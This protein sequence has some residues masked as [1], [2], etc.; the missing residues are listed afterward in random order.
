MKHD[1][2]DNQESKLADHIN[3]ILTGSE[4]AKFAVGYLFLSGL[5]TIRE[6]LDELKSLRILIGNTSNRETLE[7]ITEGFQRLELAAEVDERERYLKR[8]V[9]KRRSE[10]TAENL[11]HSIEKIDQTD[12]SQELVRLLI[13]MIEEKRLLVRIYTKGRLHAKA[14]I[15]DYPNQERYENGIAIVGS[16]NLTLSGLTHNTEL[17]V[18]VHGN[19]NHLRL[20]Q[21]FDELW[22]DAQ[23]FNPLLTEE[24]RESWAAAMVTPYDVYMKTLY[25]LVADRLDEGDR[26]E[27]LWDDELT[28]SLADFQKTAV[29]QAVQMIRDTGGAFISDVVGLGKSYIGAAVVKHFVRTQGATPLIICPKSLEE[30]WQD[31]NNEFS[32]GA[33]ILPMSLLRSPSQASASP[34]LERKTYRACDFV[35]IDESH[36][37][38]HH[39]SQRYEVMSDF[40]S[41]GLKKVC[42]ITATPR[43]RGAQDVYNQIKL[44]HQD[45]ITGLPVDPPNLKEYFKLVE[46]GEKRLQ[47][48]LVHILIR[49]TRRHI[50]RWY[51]YAQDTSQALKEFSDVKARPYICGEKKAYVLVGGRHQFFPKRELETLRYS[52]E[53]TYTGLYDRIRGYLGGPAGEHYAP[54]P[55]KELTYARY[56]LWHYVRPEK[57]KSAP[58][59]DLQ[60]AGINLRGLVRVMLF[61]R[62]ESSVF[63][64]R[65]TLERLDKIHGHFLEA[66][67]QGFVPAGQDAQKLLYESDVYDDEGLMDALY[68]C[69]GRYH[70]TDFDE[71][72]LRDHLSADQE[73]VRKILKLVKPI[74]PDQ[75]AKIQVLLGGLR[76]GIPQRRGKVLIF[77]QYADTAQYLY[78]NLN[79]GEE[80]SDIASI[81]GTGKSKARMAARFSPLSNRHMDIREDEVNVLVSTDVMSEGLNLQDCDVVV[82]YDLHWNPVRLIQRL[83]RID[84]IG[85][86]NDRVWGFNFLPERKLEKNLGLHETLKRRIQEIHDTIGEDAAILDKEEQINEEAMFAI[87]ERRGE[88]LSLFE[89]E[90]GEFLDI[91]EAEEL[92]RALRTNEPEEYERIANLREGIRSARGVFSNT[93]RF[94]LCQAGRYQQLFLTD[95]DGTVVSREV[96]LVLGRVKCSRAE[97]TAALPLDHNRVVMKVLKSFSDEVKHRKAQQQHGLSLTVGQTYVL[98]ELR[99]FYSR[100]ADEDTDLKGQVVKLEEAFRRPATAA[101]RRQ[102]NILRRNGVVGNPLVRAL[103]DLY[104][105]HGLHEQVDADRIRHEQ[106]SEEFPR[107]ICSEAFV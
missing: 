36:N 53:D 69:S 63:A 19:Q 78:E 54:R 94:I 29:R 90:Q 56:G 96:P 101:I 91:S 58:Y 87:Y 107:I 80:R 83:G 66:L 31:Y 23:D 30:M 74:T 39:S 44:F 106:E 41:R 7:Q 79:Q 68:S 62:L 72:L 17:N 75:D 14:Y 10:E 81:Y 1:I 93:G 61:K 12:D 49:R 88:Q 99:V 59:R 52:I 21:W 42:L 37:F 71:A 76:N 85:T 20:T 64:F 104:H 67:D 22:A 8:S 35:L 105:D 51:G 46:R 25:S 18:V 28:R 6:N 5:S 92:M 34:I 60:R 55:G 13:R 27:I 98:R 73:L 24:L 47:D 9:Q 95:P 70:I 40:L 15:F 86:E 43:N 77:T 100:L 102:L 65:R 33:R 16:S 32:L 103:T 2:I 48:L 3:E 26:G 84:R 57:Q 97:K 45:D 82:N 38:R 11:R 89:E 4:S 50:L